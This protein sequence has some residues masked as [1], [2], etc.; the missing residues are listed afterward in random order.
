MLTAIASRA[1]D[2]RHT[3]VAQPAISVALRAASG[4]ARAG[5]C[6]NRSPEANRATNSRA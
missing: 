2:L 5:R 6:R 4:V 1:Q 3:Y